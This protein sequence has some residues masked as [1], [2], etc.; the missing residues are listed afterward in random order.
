M[1]NSV[2]A[3]TR[4][5]HTAAAA[6]ERVGLSVVIAALFA[7]SWIGTIPQLLVSWQ[8][9]SSLSMPPELMQ[10]FI[11]A[12]GLVALVAAW[13]NGGWL[14]C[15]HLFRRLLRR[16]AALFLYAAV[17]LGPPALMLVSILLSNTLG[18]TA[19][20][21]P[22]A[23][24]AFA[25]FLPNFLAHLLL[26]TEEL[27]WRGYVLPRMQRHWSPLLASLVLGAIWIAFHAPYFFM[28][29]GHPGG[30]TPLL[31]VASLLPMSILLTRTFNAAAGSV[32]L[33]HLLHQS[34]NGWAE[35]L[36]YLPRFAGSSAPLAISATIAFVLA[37]FTIVA[38][39]SM[40]IRR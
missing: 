8:G 17:L 36:P 12:P 20:R 7:F 34:V 37:L 26:N 22:P 9:A 10:G 30:Y 40:W 24:G 23:S 29:G 6:R 14:A 32:L 4:N 18:C 28:K 13:L 38:W 39:P 11:L 31:L 25:A 16:R 15:R 33:P 35:A 2:V 1:M 5:D 27:A 21:L 3:P 19:L